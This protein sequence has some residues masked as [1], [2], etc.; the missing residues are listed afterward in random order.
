MCLKT[1]K[2]PIE[3]FDRWQV[4]DPLQRHQLLAL[5]S[6]LHHLHIEQRLQRGLQLLL[7]GLDVLG[8][9]WWQTRYIFR[10]IW[11]FS[12]LSKQMMTSH[13]FNILWSWAMWPY[14]AIY[15]TLGNFLK[16][17][18]TINLPESPTF[19]CNFCKGVKICH[20]SS[21]IIF[22]QPLQTFG[23]FF[24]VTLIV[25]DKHCITTSQ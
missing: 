17:L 10:R 12:L 5:A 1:N 14:W 24:L 3:I 19:L 11:P 16:P 4:I 9:F 7:P 8:R 23:D 20:F 15:W 25:S 6:V 22:R 2:V 21:E 13:N 18:A